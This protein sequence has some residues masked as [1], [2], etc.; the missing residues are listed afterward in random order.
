MPKTDA[1][2]ASLQRGGSVSE[3]EAPLVSVIIPF[4]NTAGFL[5]EAID[6]VLDQN[7]PNCE[8]VLVDDGSTDGSLK[9]AQEYSQR[10]PGKISILHHAGRQNCGISASRNLGLS[11]ANGKYVCFLDSDDVFLP[12]KLDLEVAILK[13]NPEAVVV[14]GAYYYWY[15]WTGLEKDLSRDFTVTLGVTPEKVHQPPSLLI[16]NLRAGGRKP[17]TSG[18][19][20]ERNSLVVQACEESFVGMGDDQIFWARLSLL[21]PVYVTDVPLFKYRQH[22]DSLCAAAM[23][24]GADSIAWQK[25]LSWLEQYFAAEGLN[26]PAIWKLLRR[27]QKNSGYLVDLAPLKRLYRRIFPIRARYWLR[28][29]WIEIQRLRH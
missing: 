17:G 19:M 3:S 24:T 9:I 8:I 2:N 26:D 20:F 10:Y 27:C 14:C 23:K 21:V 4:W 25:Y 16:H 6:S 15:S 29:R 5:A 18:I 11:R 1:P 13:A 22:P 28:D 12:G 7:Y